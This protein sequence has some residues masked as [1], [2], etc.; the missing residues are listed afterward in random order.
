MLEPALL[1]EDE[2]DPLLG[3]ASLLVVVRG[4]AWAAAEIGM[5]SPVVVT[6][7]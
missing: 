1:D 2:L 7:T 6:M 3:G 4:I 5:A